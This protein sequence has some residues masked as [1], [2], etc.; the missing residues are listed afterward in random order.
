M[1][2]STWRPARHGI[3]VGAFEADPLPFDVS[4]REGFSMEHTPLD[5]SILAKSRAT[6]E[7]YLPALKD[8]TAGE[9]RAA[10]LR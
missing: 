1:P 9:H 4:H 7:A 3:M 8:S 2:A 5:F 6:I 10:C